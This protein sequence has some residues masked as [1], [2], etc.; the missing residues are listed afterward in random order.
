MRLT[1]ATPRG[2]KI[3]AIQKPMDPP[4]K[5]PEIVNVI[6]APTI[7][8]D[9]CQMLGILRTPRMRLNPEATMKRMTVRDNP[10]KI[11]D[12]SFGERIA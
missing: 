2:A 12:I 5:A 11:W 4:P 7:Y 9:P 10:T 8:R 1:K 6:K 3:K